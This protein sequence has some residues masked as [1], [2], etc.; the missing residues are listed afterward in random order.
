MAVAFSFKQ[1]RTATQEAKKTNSVKEV[2]VA[3]WAAVGKVALKVFSSLSEIK[4]E[5][6][7]W[8][9]SSA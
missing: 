3:F 4:K 5:E 6:S 7:F 1:S 2:I 9:M 8:A